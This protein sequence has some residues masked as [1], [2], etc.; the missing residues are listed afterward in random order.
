MVEF[1]TPVHCLA[2]AERA[3]VCDV[4]PCPCWCHGPIESRRMAKKRGYS[5]AFPTTRPKRVY[6]ML[7]K[8]PPA[9]WVRVKAKARRQGI[10]LRALILGWCKEWVERDD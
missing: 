3:C 10:S 6:F 2:H 1:G 8:I 5:D 4:T 7:D 9:L